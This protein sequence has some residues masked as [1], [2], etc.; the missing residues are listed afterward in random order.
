MSDHQI[1]ADNGSPSSIVLEK[2]RSGQGRAPEIVIEWLDRSEDAAWDAFVAAHPHGTICQTTRWREMIESSFGHIQGRVLAI[3][4]GAGGPIRGGMMGYTVRSWLLGNRLVSV[5]F[6]SRVDPLT[7]SPKDLGLMLEHLDRRRG[8]LGVRS[9]QVRLLKV[10]PLGIPEGFTVH[11]NLKRHYIVLDRPLDELYKETH[12]SC[13]RRWIKKARRNDVVVR[14][15]RTGRDWDIL[16]RIYGHTRQRLRLPAMPRRFFSAAARCL[17]PGQV[18]LFIVEKDGKP[19]GAGLFLIFNGVQQLEW[20]GDTDEGRAVGANQLLYW[21]ALTD[22]VN[23]GCH[24]F[25]F[26]RTDDDNEGLLDYKRR[27]GSIEEDIHVVASGKGK[28]SSTG[29]RADAGITRSIAERIVVASPRPL[30]LGFSEFCYRHL[31]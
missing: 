18:E 29:R 15:G 31:G 28:G 1:G 9:L 7:S 23:R 12:A 26:G 25:C 17:E 20:V 24:T 13:V 22:A 2:S 30:Y 11:S 4:D 27:W 6:A 10:L 5:P 3:R 14:R 19:L 21:E 8:D 16:F